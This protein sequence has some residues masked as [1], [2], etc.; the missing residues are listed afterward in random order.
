MSAVVNAARSRCV[1]TPTCFLH[2][3]K[4]AGSSV[5][6]ALEA[7]LPPGSLAPRRFDRAV[8]TDF[9]DFGLLPPDARELIALEDGEVQA[10]ARYRA[11]SG[12]FSLSTLLRI[13]DPAAIGTVL[14]EPRARLLSLFTYWRV[15]SIDDFWAP[16]LMSDQARRPLCEFLTEPRLAPVVDNQIC[17][18]LLYGDPRLPAARFAAQADVESIALDA[19]ERLEALGF[20]GCV[21]CGEQVWRGLAELFGVR[22]EPARV[23]ATDELDRPLAAAPGERLLAGETLELLELRTAADRLV[24]DHALARTGAGVE[25]RARIAQGAFAQQLVKLGDLVGHSAARLVGLQGQER[26][27]EELRAEVRR[28]EED[29]ERLRGW[30][31]AVHASASWRLTAPLRAAKHGLGGMPPLLRGHLRPPGG[32]TPLVAERSLL[33]GCSVRQVWWFA[34]ALC[35]VIAATDAVLTHVVLIAV[36]TVGPVCCVLT[37]RW[38]RTASVG[39]WA[40]A[41]AVLLGVPD[42]I[43]GTHTQ[44]IDLV[45]V[46]TS[47]MLSTS[48]AS[49]IERHRS[50]VLG[51]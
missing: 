13:A 50:A 28:Q 12:H 43:W 9:C 49:L 22:L 18:M 15:P 7:A 39:L 25:E 21:E 37:G 29:A 34:L 27:V 2:V 42:R 8:F 45:A 3:P 20:V 11:V 46:A 41:L 5:H 32:S 31:E 35:A 40:F 33:A 38:V 14:R 30:L 36:L 10:L 26:T 6:A 51:R 47:A 19:A 24:Y 16:Y 48:A 23:N 44:V 4:C 1:T 17:R